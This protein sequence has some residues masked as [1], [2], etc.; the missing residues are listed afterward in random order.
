MSYARSCGPFRLLFCRKPAAYQSF[1]YP[2]A[3]SCLAYLSPSDYSGPLAHVPCLQAQS[4]VSWSLLR[5]P[6]SLLLSYLERSCDLQPL[7]WS[8]LKSAWYES[9]ARLSSLQNYWRHFGRWP[10]LC[11]SRWESTKDVFSKTYLHLLREGHALRFQV[12]DFDLLLAQPA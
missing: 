8:R 9:E 11:V 1:I 6:C 12:L 7:Q 5:E 3:P 10:C 2:F 4:W